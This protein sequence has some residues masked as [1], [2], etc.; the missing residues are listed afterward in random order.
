[1]FNN[2]G[3]SPAFSNHISDSRLCGSCHTLLTSSVDLSGNLTG[4]QFVEQA[5]YQEW[6]NSE[7]SELQNSCQDCHIPKIFETVKISLMPPWLEGRSPFGLHHLTGANKFMQEILSN[8]IDDLG[9]TANTVQFD[10]TIDRTL[11]MLQLS[12]AELTVE[13]AGRTADTLFLSVEIENKAGHK[14]P[15]GFPSRRAYVEIVIIN[16]EHD[17]LFHSGKTDQNGQLLFEAHPY[18]AHH[19]LISSQLETQIYEMVMGDVNGDVTTVL[20]RGHIPLKDNRLPPKGFT[21]VH[22]SYDTVAISGLAT[23]DENFNK[24]DGEEGTG[25]D[26]IFVHAPINGYAGTLDIQVRLHYQTVSERWMEEMFSFNSTPIDLWEN[27]YQSSNRE[28]IV[29]AESSIESAAVIL[30]ETTEITTARIFPNP[31]KGSLYISADPQSFN[32]ILLFSI[33]GSLV[34]YRKHQ[35][36]SNKLNFNGYK[37]TYLLN[38]R[39]DG[40]SKISVKIVFI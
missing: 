21:T 5:V 2:T 35:I 38:L 3:Y 4:E 17:T 31:S 15:T 7:H 28:S 18:E 11:R 8:N 32:E 30:N 16:Q 27:I 37:G 26:L 39:K 23:G 19:S 24:S 36:G 29:I 34:A 22:P 14:L 33:S 1:M 13:E 25:K 20:E 12:T 6:L 10:S 9:I 40:E